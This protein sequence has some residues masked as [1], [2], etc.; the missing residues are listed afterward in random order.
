MTQV[1][2]LNAGYRGLVPFPS[3]FGQRLAPVSE[4]RE[5]APRSA[6]LR[7]ESP[8]SYHADIVGYPAVIRHALVPLR[9]AFGGRRLP[10]LDLVE[11]IEPVGLAALVAKQFIALAGSRHHRNRPEPRGQITLYLGLERMFHPHV[12]AV[13]IGGVGMHHRGIGP[14]GSP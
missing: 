4:G 11:I 6:S 9:G 10:E 2:R 14:A 1:C 3:L 13:R 12:G 8:S 5:P 7:R